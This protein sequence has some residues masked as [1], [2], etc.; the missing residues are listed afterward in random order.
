[1]TT[2]NNMEINCKSILIIDDDRIFC[3]LLKTLLNKIIPDITVEIYDIL[4]RGEPD[5]QYNWSAYDLVIMDYNLGGG[6]NGVDWITKYKNRSGFP[7]AIVLTAQGSEDLIVEVMQ[8]GARD[9]IN[10]QKLSLERLTSA[11]RKAVGG[12]AVNQEIT[13]AGSGDMTTETTRQQTTIISKVDF[14][15]KMDDLLNSGNEGYHP[16]LFQMEINDYRKIQDSV[17]MLCADEYINRIT[18]L[19]D[20]FLQEKQF[21]FNL[22]L[23]GDSKIAGYITGYNDNEG[24]VDKIIDSLCEDISYSVRIDDRTVESTVAVGVV[25]IEGNEGLDDLFDEVDSVCRNISDRNKNS[26]YILDKSSAPDTGEEVSEASGKEEKEMTGEE[27]REKGETRIDIAEVIKKK[28]QQIRFQ[29]FIPLSE[30]A[31]NLGFN[32]SQIQVHVQNENG[33]SYSLEDLKAMDLKDK[34]RVNLDLWIIGHALGE[35][36]KL[37]VQNKELKI[38]LFI[39]LSREA[40]SS[41]LVEGTD[42]EK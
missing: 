39:S 17:G 7:P 20:R 27:D 23:I 29:S 35:I 33:Y 3:N 24:S 37:K 15:K 19:L 16:V 9:Y 10:K 42:K 8:A 34:H 21:Q 12:R 1:M 40:L 38:G 4:N 18:G 2:D 22:T 6:R 5:D 32:Y 13:D 28:R 14:Y 11:I 25:M 26:Y 41:S 36:I 30:T 31:L